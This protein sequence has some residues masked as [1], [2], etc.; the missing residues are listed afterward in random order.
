[1]TSLKKLSIQTVDT[2]ETS[3]TRLAYCP[4]NR[5]LAA[6]VIQRHMN[7]ETGDIEQRASLELRDPV[8]MQS[9]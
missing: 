7:R 6:G 4:V 1:V 3:S 9:M 5:V 2:G 8:S